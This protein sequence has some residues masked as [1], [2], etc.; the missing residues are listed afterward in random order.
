MKAHLKWVNYFIGFSAQ[1]CFGLMTLTMN[2][3]ASRLA[4][5]LE[6]THEGNFKY[7]GKTTLDT[8]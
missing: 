3:A 5:I 8:Q 4:A 2:V 6:P 1:F 7:H